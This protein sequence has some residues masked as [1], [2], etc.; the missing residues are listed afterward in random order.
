MSSMTIGALASEAACTVPTIRYYEEIG[1]LP[2]A[3][4]RIGGHRVYADPDLQRLRF[5]R[6]CRD[7]GFPI[8]E[9]RKL[10][11]LVG[12]PVRD[13][14]EAR[15][16]VAVHLGGIRRKLKDLLGL[17]RSLKTFVSA[18]N[19]QCVGGPASD[20]VILE[21]LTTYQ[22]SACCPSTP[23]RKLLKVVETNCCS[24]KV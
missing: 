1:L 20:C 13:C 18:C 24:G 9:I 11:A 2:K 4:R 5:I 17:E 10:V 7:F 19:A 8:D 12:S 15:D 23:V 14:V 22:K 3:A 16:V 21:D 6:R